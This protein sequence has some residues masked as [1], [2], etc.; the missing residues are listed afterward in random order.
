MISEYNHRHFGIL[1]IANRLPIHSILNVRGA[2]QNDT[3]NTNSALAGKN[4]TYVMLCYADVISSRRNKIRVHVILVC[5][6]W[7]YCRIICKIQ[8]I[9][10]VRKTRYSNV[11]S[12]GN[13]IYLDNH[14][15]YERNNTLSYI[16][17]R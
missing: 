12:M 13:F 8:I 17:V 2:I 7:I 5:F 15:T 11:F 14:F 6:Y 10:A 9:S 16:C 4:N 1:L 3:L